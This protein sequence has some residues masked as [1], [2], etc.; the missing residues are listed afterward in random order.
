MTIAMQPIFT[1]TVGAG[2]AAS[3]V[4]NNIPQTFT[5]LQIE[6]S[7]RTTD[8]TLSNH[9]SDCLFRF[10]GVTS[11]YSSTWL[12]NNTGSPSSFRATGNVWGSGLVINGRLTAANTFA[13]SGFVLPNYT[14]SAFK[15]WSAYSSPESNTANFDSANI[16]VAGLWS[17]TA[18]ITSITLVDGYGNFAQHSTFTLYGITKG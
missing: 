1:Q 6:V 13:S 14:S 17:N 4:F 16:Y 2:G 5:D 3:V 11:G 9:V 12:R 15:S 10:N 8:T 18:P 7:G